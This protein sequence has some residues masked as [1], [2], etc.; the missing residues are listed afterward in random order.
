M[1][2]LQVL[3]NLRQ[4]VLQE[5]LVLSSLKLNVNHLLV[6]LFH[7]HLHCLELLLSRRLTA[8]NRG[9]RSCDLRMQILTVILDIAYLLSEL[10]DLLHDDLVGLARAPVRVYLLVLCR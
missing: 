7:L 3:S 1:Q 9:C 6:C 2:A 10:L 8:L 4:L 5:L